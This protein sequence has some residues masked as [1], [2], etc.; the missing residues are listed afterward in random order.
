MSQRS[1]SLCTGRR[2]R[3][4]RHPGRPALALSHDRLAAAAAAPAAPARRS[5]SR[6]RRRTRARSAS[7]STGWRWS[8]GEGRFVLTP[9]SCAAARARRGRRVRASPSRRRAARVGARCTPRSCSRPGDRRAR[10]GRD[11]LRADRRR[12]R[13]ALPR[14]RSAGALAARCAGCARRSSWTRRASRAR[15]SLTRCARSPCASCSMLHPQ[16]YYPDVKVHALFAWQLARHG[17]VALPARS[18]RRTSTGSASASSSR[19]GTGTRSPTRRSFYMLCWPLVRLARY[20]PEVAVSVVAAVVNSLEAWIVFGIARRLR[21]AP[22][23]ALAGRGRAGGAAHLHRASDPRVFPRPRRTCRGRRGAPRDPRPPARPGRARGDRARGLSSRVALLTYTQS[24]LNFAVLVP[25]IVIAHLATIALP[26]AAADGGTRGRDALGGVIALAA[27]Y[28][29]YV[30]I[31][32]DMRRASRWP[33]SRSSSRSRRRHAARG[34]EP[35]VVEQDD[36]YAGPE[37][38]ALRGVRKAGWRHVRLLR[39]RSRL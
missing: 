14:D 32:I 6:P 25:L 1:Y 36:P 24:L 34:G 8:R 26:S 21:C 16:F 11:R 17:L 3:P 18:S 10:V 13:A 33:R 20:R 29:R 2:D 19:T 22:P 39:R 30:P 38:Y 4:V 35:A 28:G 7:P 9:R 31:F 15:W 12:R 27:F 37:F 23:T 5:R